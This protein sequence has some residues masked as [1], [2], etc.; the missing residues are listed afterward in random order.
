MLRKYIRSSVWL[1]SMGLGTVLLAGCSTDPKVSYGDAR[2]EETVAVNF[3]ST[4]LQVIAKTMVDELLAF[5]PLMAAMGN[6]R[7][8]IVVDKVKNKT[9]EHIDTESV[10]DSIQSQ[11]LRSG[12]FRFVDQSVLNAVQAQM[13]W[14][15]D[16]GLV[17]PAKAALFGKQV[18]AKFMLYGNLAGIEK[19]N[20][21]TKDVYYKFTLKLMDLESGLVEWIGE[22]EIRKIAEKPWFSSF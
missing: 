12:H 3:G 17:D 16:S 21:K 14:Q 2:A 4:D 22:K 13:K 19:R 11:L 8:V 9:L 18:G 10:T 7:P 6:T 20:S 15:T 5:Q 1:V